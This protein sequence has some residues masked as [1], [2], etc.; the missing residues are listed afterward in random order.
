M[1]PSSALCRAQESLHRRRAADT[2]LENVRSVSISA[3]AAW[4]KEALAAES[5]EA[6]QLRAQAVANA[7]SLMSKACAVQGDVSISENGSRLRASLTPTTHFGTY[8]IAKRRR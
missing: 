7:K 6:R 5:R 2:T 4:A 1:I 3:A 8:A